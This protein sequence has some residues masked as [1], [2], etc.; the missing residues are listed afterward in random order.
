[1]RTPDDDPAFLYQDV[2]VELD[3]EQ[4]INIGE[5]SLH[6]HGLDPLAPQPRE[7]VLQ[8][9][10]GSGYY[11]AILA[12]LVG[13]EGRVLDFEIDPAL[14]ERARR[15][16]AP[17]PQAS[18]EVRSGVADGLPQADAIYVNAG[19]TQPSWAWLDT[20]RLGGVLIFPLQPQGGWGG[21]LMLPKPKEGGPAWPA[22]FVS[23]AAFIACQARQDD[24]TGR[25]LMAAF[26]D[27]GFEIVRS[28]RFGG[29]PDY[30]CWFDGRD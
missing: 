15:N 11:T 13:P 3:A 4:G 30:T 20:L 28:F 17:W 27:G 26:K 29:R 9:G 1:M 22:R 18:V 19:I 16:L 14:A 12:H 2:L 24:G 10:A 7:T 8:V 23:R 25:Q 6:S 21:M 5:P